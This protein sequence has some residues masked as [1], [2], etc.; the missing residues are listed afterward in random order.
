MNEYK[1]AVIIPLWNC[2]DYVSQ[3]L[4]CMQQQTF[5][6]WRLFVID[7]Q[8]TDNGAE[9]VR[10]Y[11]AGDSRINLFVRDCEPKGAQTCRN[12]G[13]ELSE[14][15]K[16]VIWFDADDL[17]ATYCLEQRVAYMDS[18]ADLDFAIFPAKK[19]CSSPFDSN[20]ELWGY[21]FL[22]DTLRCFLNR[23]L[24][25]V[26]WTNIYRR[27]SIEDHN[28]RWDINILSL[29]DADWNIQAI[30]SGMKYEYASKEDA[31]IDYFYRYVPSG[32]A[33]KI[34]TAKHCAS[35]IYHIDK[36]LKSLSPELLDKYDLDIRS[37]LLT[38]AS[39]FRQHDSRAYDDFL[40]IEWFQSH[41]IDRLKL[42]ILKFTNGRGVYRLFKKEMFYR[43]AINHEWWQYRKDKYAEYVEHH[44]ISKCFSNLRDIASQGS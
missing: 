9:I 29:Q 17:I 6:E 1:L 32:I 30:L 4:D 31:K 20:D 8:S 14:G 33:A 28:L 7:D 3:M 26:G 43:D 11:A 16:Y 27:Q 23:T 44:D 15:A 35:H 39:V 19:F 34:K 2:A 18:H 42:R 21:D 22:G 40:N 41:K 13:F 10:R 5:K 12:I 24:M 25:V 37:C 38:F 36:T